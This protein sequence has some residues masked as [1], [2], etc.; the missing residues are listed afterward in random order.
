MSIP[1]EKHIKYCSCI[2][3]VSGGKARNPYAI[4]NRIKPPGKGVVHC[5]HLYDFKA[6]EAEH[7]LGYAKLK[8][9]KLPVKL[10]SDT[11]KLLEEKQNL[12]KAKKTI[13]KEL[14]NEIAKKKNQLVKQL[15]KKRKAELKGKGIKIQKVVKPSELRKAK[16]KAKKSNP[17]SKKQPGCPAGKE[18]NP[19]TGR[20]RK[21]CNLNQ[22]RNPKTGRCRVKCKP[23][24]TRDPKTKR[25]RKT[26]SGP[27]RKKTS[28]DSLKPGLKKIL[29]QSHP[30][31]VLS[32]AAAKSLE[33]MLN[34]LSKKI[35]LQ[36][37]N[38]NPTIAQLDQ[39][40]KKSVGDTPLAVIIIKDAKS[41]GNGIL[42]VKPA[43]L[44]KLLE[45]LA[46]QVFELAGN[47]AMD[48]GMDVVIP[49]YIN[50]AINMDSEL[51]K[52]LKA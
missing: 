45:S 17:K 43:Y 30:E 33:V 38:N 26:K 35:M 24:Q 5:L 3:K 12:K 8:K 23:D 37:G 49:K 42:K 50:T 41:S 51:I 9:Y 27:A 22:V 28:N 10:E 15:N 2:I 21:A 20:C 14:T 7:L 34:R 19:G 4:C 1:T 32:D 39:A 25:C 47:V 11:K 36:A 16:T 52:A 18:L 48:E 29:V 6:Y 46:G 44:A 40:V 13:P 31:L